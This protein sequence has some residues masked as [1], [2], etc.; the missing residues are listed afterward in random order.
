MSVDREAGTDTKTIL[1][2]DSENSSRITTKWFLNNFGYAV[3]SI[4]SAEEALA[5]FDPKI[6]DLIVT[7]NSMPGMSGAELAHIIKLR[8][9]STPVVMYTDSPPMDSACLD[10]VL[11]KPIHL[12]ILKAGVNRLLVES[13]RSE[14]NSSV[15]L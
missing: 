10:L 15:P 4:R 8:S 13:P 9:S 3:Q 11:Q 14:H 6:H 5:L 1:L 2:V 7:D 12:M